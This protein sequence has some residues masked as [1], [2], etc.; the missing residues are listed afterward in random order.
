MKNAKQSSSLSAQIADAIRTAIV[1]GRLLVGDRLPSE[2]ELA[3]QHGVS[4]ATVREALK[5]LGLDPREH[6]PR[7]LLS[8]ISGLVIRFMVE[9]LPFGRHET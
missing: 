1:D 5:E 3:D 7:A 8:R 9:L 4:R 2:A 6:P